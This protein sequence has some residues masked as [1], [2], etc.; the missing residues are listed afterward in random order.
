MRRIK[1]IIAALFLIPPI[2]ANADVIEVVFTGTGQYFDYD[3]G[4]WV[5]DVTLI[6]TFTFDSGD[7]PPNSGGPNSAGIVEEGIYQHPDAGSPN[8]FAKWLTATLETSDGLLGDASGINPYATEDDF[9]SEG[10]IIEDGGESV[11]NEYLYL[12]VSGFTSTGDYFRASSVW[13]DPIE[14][15]CTNG[16]TIDDVATDCD[17]TTGFSRQEFYQQGADGQELINAI[18]YNITY[19]AINRTSVPEPGALAL[20]GIGLFGMGLSRR[21]KNA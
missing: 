19:V 21:K 15:G 9:G 18:G 11:L 10:M 8:P 14:R 7:I 1:L 3:A 4:A 2:G 5:Y 13:G 12:Y 16:I 20:L 17:T 6:T